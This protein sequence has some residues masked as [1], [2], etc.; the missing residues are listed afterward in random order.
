MRWGQGGAVGRA[1]GTWERSRDVYTAAD[2]VAVGGEGGM[3]RYEGQG[4]RPHSLF[5]FE[6]PL[7][8]STAADTSAGWTRR[9]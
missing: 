8:S 5:V 3:E 7:S 1:D 4:A 2:V 9:R 6:P